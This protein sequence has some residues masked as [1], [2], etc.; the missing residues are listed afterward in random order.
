MDESAPPE[1][2]IIRFDDKDLLFA[3]HDATLL[4][5]ATKDE[6]DIWNSKIEIKDTYDFTDF[7]SIKEYADSDKSKLQD[8]LSTTLNNF[9][10]ASSEYGVIKTYDVIIKFETK[11]G[12]F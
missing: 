7:K 10:V 3:L 1:D 8:I 9:A 4:V 12:K 6:G 2:I 5:E 11:E